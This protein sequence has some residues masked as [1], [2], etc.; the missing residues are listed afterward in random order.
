MP[1]LEILPGS[2]RLTPE[3]NK[4]EHCNSATTHTSTTHKHV[5]GQHSREGGLLESDGRTH[6]HRT[7]K[8]PAEAVGMNL[9]ANVYLAGHRKRSRRGD[10]R[11][12]HEEMKEEQRNEGG[13]GKRSAVLQ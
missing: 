11:A 4:P 6:R 13:K 8:T 9:I 2:C 1:E 5:D 7:P 12:K 3:R 10:V